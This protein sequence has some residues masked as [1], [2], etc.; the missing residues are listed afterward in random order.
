[1]DTILLRCTTEERASLVLKANQII[2]KLEDIES[3]PGLS[4]EEVLSKTALINLEMNLDRFI[5]GMDLK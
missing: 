5:K 3:I 1:M 2:R 4:A